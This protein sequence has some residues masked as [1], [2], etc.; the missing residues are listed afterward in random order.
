MSREMM[1]RRTLGVATVLALLV[2]GSASAQVWLK[3]RAATDWQ[4]VAIDY[5]CLLEAQVDDIAAA[6]L[7]PE[8]RTVARFLRP[9]ELD[10]VVARHTTVKPGPR[11]FRV[12][13]KGE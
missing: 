7:T 8:Q 5:R 12:T 10:A 9:D 13:P 4:K 3:D 2:P 6:A 11:V 1:I